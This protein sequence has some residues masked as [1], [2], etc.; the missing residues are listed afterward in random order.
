MFFFRYKFVFV[1]SHRLDESHR[2]PMVTTAPDANPG[3]YE[4]RYSA[5][6]NSLVRQRYPIPSFFPDPSLK[7]GT[8]SN[9]E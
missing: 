2:Q 9:L 5:G 4:Q 3:H 1:L 7:N 6:D 8:L